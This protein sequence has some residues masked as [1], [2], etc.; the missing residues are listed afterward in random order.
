[1]EPKTTVS[2]TPGSALPPQPWVHPEG[3]AI[4]GLCARGHR[5]L[6]VPDGPWPFPHPQCPIPG[7][8]S[9]CQRERQRHR[10]S[11]TRLRPRSRAHC[12]ASCHCASRRRHRPSVALQLR[13]QAQ[14]TASSLWAPWAAAQRLQP[15]RML[16]RGAST[17]RMVTAPRGR[18]R[19][20]SL[21]SEAGAWSDSSPFASCE[22]WVAGGW[23]A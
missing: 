7:P 21:P 11:R 16:G 13:A 5:I 2:T 20:P 8:D 15:R 17:L 1:M 4:A 9:L 18:P 19:P 10:A 23:K 3:G 6:G 22:E 12:S 14:R